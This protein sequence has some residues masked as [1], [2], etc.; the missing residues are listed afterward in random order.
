MTNNQPN[1]I[2][3]IVNE[4]EVI[5]MRK[6]VYDTPKGTVTTLEEAKTVGKYTTRLEDVREVAK[7]MTEERK[8][9]LEKYF[10]KLR[11]KKI[12]DSI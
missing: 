4:R 10:A 12:V 7:P 11:V 3:I 8:R 1:A 9:K 2:I 6:L 5:S